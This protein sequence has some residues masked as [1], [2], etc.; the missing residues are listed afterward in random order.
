[1]IRSRRRQQVEAG[2][3]RVV[4]TEGSSSTADDRSPRATAFN[5]TVA[6]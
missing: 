2:V 5:V 3:Y 4:V 6:S 1:M